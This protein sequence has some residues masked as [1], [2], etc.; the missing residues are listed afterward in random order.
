VYWNIED[1]H[2]NAV[3]L[4]LCA[5]I[6]TQEVNVAPDLLRL[7]CFENSNFVQL[8]SVY[9][10]KTSYNSDFGR[11]F[12]DPS[13]SGS[14]AEALDQLN[15]TCLVMDE[16]KL[17]EF[18]PECDNHQEKIKMLFQRSL[19]G[20]YSVLSTLSPLLTIPSGICALIKHAYNSI[21]DRNFA[22]DVYSGRRAQQQ[23]SLYYPLV[24]LVLQGIVCRFFKEPFEFNSM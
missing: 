22:F 5:A 3:F 1:R 11:F 12:V 8:F 7:F 24:R 10:L 9:T 2:I 4:S 15:D 14:L 18:V 16:Q 17:I 21:V 23:Y 20:I 19:D 13:V 6:C